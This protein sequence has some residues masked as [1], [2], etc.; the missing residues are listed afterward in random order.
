MI[1]DKSAFKLAEEN[2]HMEVLNF[3]QEYEKSNKL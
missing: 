3:L 1:F 2:G